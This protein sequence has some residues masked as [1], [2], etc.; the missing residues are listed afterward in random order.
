MRSCVKGL[1]KLYSVFLTSANDQFANRKTLTK[2]SPL[3]QVNHLMS[4]KVT[5]N[6]PTR[7]ETSYAFGWAGSSS[8]EEWVT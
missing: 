6:P 4:T 1:L 2:D 5:M 8:L 7:S 3:K